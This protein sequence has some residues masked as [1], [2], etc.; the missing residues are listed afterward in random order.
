MKTN[1][2]LLIVCISLFALLKEIRAGGGT[3]G[4]EPVDPLGQ[5]NDD[6]FDNSYESSPQRDAVMRRRIYV[7][8]ERML[9]LLCYMSNLLNFVQNI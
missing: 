2:M 6:Y 3:G 4:T 9:K 1:S 5:G 8:I 7:L